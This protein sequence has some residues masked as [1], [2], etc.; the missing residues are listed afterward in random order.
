MNV[1][2]AFRGK[3]QLPALPP[4][5]RRRPFQRMASTASV[6]GTPRTE[7]KLAASSRSD[8]E[9]QESRLR[10]IARQCAVRATPASGRSSRSIWELDRISACLYGALRKDP[11]SGIYFHVKGPS[12]PFTDRS[13]KGWLR[14]DSIVDSGGV[15]L[16]DVRETFPHPISGVATPIGYLSKV[17]YWILLLSCGRAFGH[18]GSR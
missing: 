13:C 10:R 8:Q 18:H 15:P 3:P 12:R 11:R 1:F 17:T 14:H 9:R 7:S 2:L 4:V 5:A 6:V 16:I